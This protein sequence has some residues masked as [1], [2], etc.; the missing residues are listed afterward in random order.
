[1]LQYG[2]FFYIPEIIWFELISW[3]HNNLLEGHFGID[4]T[5]ELIVKKYY[6]PTLCQD[7]KVYVKGYIIYLAFKVVQYK[8]YENL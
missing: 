4:K 1:M 3:H 5:Q 8:L 7:I 2:S 6:W